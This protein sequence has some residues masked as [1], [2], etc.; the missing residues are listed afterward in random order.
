[1]ASM[2]ERRM[3]TMAKCVNQKVTESQTL[4]NVN[5]AKLAERDALLMELEM[6]KQKVDDFQQYKNFC[7]SCARASYE[8]YSSYYH[9]MFTDV[10]DGT[11]FEEV[12]KKQEEQKSPL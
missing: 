4:K 6:K 8:K 12:E 1:M 9:T 2:F 11:L 10:K 3:S 7:L 5:R